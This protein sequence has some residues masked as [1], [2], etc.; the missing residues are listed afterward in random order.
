[1]TSATPIL[2]CLEKE[3]VHRKNSIDQKN[4]PIKS[5]ITYKE[6]ITLIPNQFLRK[7][8]NLWKHNGTMM[9]RKRVKISNRL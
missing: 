2:S 1:M 7:E 6:T 3:G 8:P 5:D 4:C 9:K